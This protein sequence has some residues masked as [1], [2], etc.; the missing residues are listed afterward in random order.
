MD[1]AIKGRAAIYFDAQEVLHIVKNPL[2]LVEGSKIVEIGKEEDVKKDLVGHDRIG[3][4]NQLLLPGL[5]NCHTHLGMTLFRGLSDDLPLITWLNE[6]IWPLEGKLNEQRV[7]DGALLGAIESIAGGV[8]T[9]DSM[10]WYPEAEIKAMSTVGM[11]GIVGLPIIEDV[12]TVNQSMEILKH[13]HNS[14]DGKI[15]A[16]LCV[17]APYTASIQIYKE[18]NIAI[19]EYNEHVD[20]ANRIN[21]HTHLAE[22]DTEFEQAKKLNER[23]E[24]KFPDS[25]SSPTELL[26]KI[27]VLDENILAAHCIHMSDRDMELLKK[28]KVRVSLNPLSNS[29]LG[30]H[31][32]NLPRYIEEIPLAGLGTD[33]PASNNT[34]DLFDTI[35]YISLYYKG[36]NRDPTV[37]KAE[38]VLKLATIRGAKALRWNGLGTLEKGSLADIITINLKKPHL[39]PVVNEQSIISHF[40]YSMKGSD[41]ENTI[42]NGE[43]VYENNEHKNSNV[44]EL[45]DKV[46]KTIQ[47]MMIE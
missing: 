21:L 10:Y 30:N 35:R 44:L 32:P 41:V 29:K 12:T 31:M 7:Y 42:I 17:H 39:T 37:V 19:K 28:N 13:H 40:A 45:M 3:D 2:I 15:R 25:I 27:G 8:T 20:E 46:E 36:Y 6:H 24:Q 14:C 5:I 26:D 9:L 4:A 11:R 33:G 22:A 1:L 23:K 47:E 43:I 38:E 16:D 18:A 34:Q